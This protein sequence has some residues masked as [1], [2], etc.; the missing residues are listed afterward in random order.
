MDVRDVWMDVRRLGRAVANTGVRR[1]GARARDWR[2]RGRA[3]SRA[4]GCAAVSAR[5]EEEEA[6]TFGARGGCPWAAHE[7]HGSRGKTKRKLG[8]RLVAHS[9]FLVRIE[10]RIVDMRG[11]TDLMSP[12]L[13]LFVEKCLGFV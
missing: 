9:K 6:E 5:E 12:R 11:K 10:R 8:S 7:P 2:V 3:G 1:A 13:T 4:C